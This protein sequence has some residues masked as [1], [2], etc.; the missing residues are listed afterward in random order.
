MTTLYQW[1]D[2]SNATSGIITDW[3]GAWA[4][5]TDYNIS[6]GVENDGSSY[7]CKLAHTSGAT[8]E[9]GVGASWTTYWDLVASKGDTGQSPITVSTTAP[10]SPEVNQ[11]WLDIN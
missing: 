6:E 11:L 3:K 10:E 9:P 7:I 5:S 2:G 4:T 8:S 1:E